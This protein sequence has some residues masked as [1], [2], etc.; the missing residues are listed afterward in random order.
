MDQ[1]DVRGTLREMWVT[2]PARPREGRQVAGVA[3]AI[4]R[5]YA[6]DPV[7]VRVGFVVAAIYGIGLALYL[8]GWL[9]LPG[10]DDIPADR[11]TARPRPLILVA[12]AALVVLSLSSVVGSEDEYGSG[13]GIVLP[14]IAAL[15][16]LVLLH[17]SRG[18]HG[19]TTTVPATHAVPAEP[20]GT[21]EAGT[22]E[23]GTTVAATTATE[24][25]APRP[26]S[27][28]PLG[29]APFAW[30][31]PEPSPAPA[32]PPAPRIPVTAVTLGVALLAGALVTA[33]LLLGGGFVPQSVQV[34]SGVVLGVIGLGL[35]VGAFL[36]SGHGLV[37]VA[38]LVGLLTWGMAAAPL[39]NWP[40]GG[41]GDVRIAPT[42]AAELAPSYTHSAGDMDIDLRRLDL[43]VAPGG[44]ASPVPLAVTIGAGDV[45]IRVPATADVTFTGSIGAGNVAFSGDERSGFPAQLT[46]TDDLGTDGV[47]SG[48]PLE[49]TVH[50]NLGN[51]E[52]LRG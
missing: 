26:P 33:L 41:V 51:V 10:G 9:L 52:V 24:P 16:L 11:R 2:R 18:R 31:L 37:P 4:G 32:P 34:L 36:H 29:A 25:D 22:P 35:V 15:G 21:T 27:W 44:V 42:S 49:I 6:V 1:T 30:D 7:L 5:R 45:Q 14:T 40:T 38:V 39:E 12:V 8:A 20:A 13:G 17:V 48:R 47:A 3:A 19:A 50:A 23:A 43:A 46:V 28:D